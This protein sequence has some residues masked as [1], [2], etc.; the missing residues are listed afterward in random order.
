MN[1]GI[2]RLSHMVPN[3]EYVAWCDADIDFMNPDWAVET[4]HAL[5]HYD[6]VQPW[7]TAIDLGPTGEAM[8][9]HESFGWC[10][11]TD[12]AMSITWKPYTKFGH[13]GFCWAATREALDSVGLLYEKAILGAGDHH[14]AWALLGHAKNTYPKGVS[15]QYAQ[16]ILHWQHRALK[17]IKKNV[18]FV[19]GTIQHHWHGKKKDRKYIDRWRILIDYQFNP[20]TDIYR[21][22]QGL[23][24][25]V[26]DDSDRMIGLRD[27]IRRY[28]RGRN[29]DSID[30]D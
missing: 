3:W 11:A 21:D 6:I 23:F 24:R 7:Q 2:Q 19:P 1:L 16:S 15:P 27:A 14:M 29:E 13:P 17:G 12:K 9:I 5:Q 18:G 26:D 25:L 8:A 30:L 28:F 22:P 4:V 10:V 20:E